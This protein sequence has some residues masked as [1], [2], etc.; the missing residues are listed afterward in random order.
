MP[1]VA[2]AAAVDDGDDDEDDDDADIDDIEN[3]D[4][5]DNDCAG[6]GGLAM[7]N[8]VFVGATET[9]YFV[10]LAAT[11]AAAAAAAADTSRRSRAIADSESIFKFSRR[12]SLARSSFTLRDNKSRL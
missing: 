11:A 1:G 3:G 7:T 4:D 5:G 6:D 2:V 9:A 8:V 12:C 10:V